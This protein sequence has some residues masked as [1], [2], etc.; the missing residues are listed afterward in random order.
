MYDFIT[1]AVL[2]A[3]IDAIKLIPFLYLTYLFMEFLEHRTGERVVNAI[4]KAGRF[5]PLAGGLLGAVPQC[6]FS[7]VASG[8]YSGRIITVGTLIAVFLST[9]DEMVAVMLSSAAKDPENLARL[10]KILGIKVVGG[11]A[12]GFAADFIL[13]NRKIKPDKREIGEICDH[14]GCHCEEHGIFVSAA[15]HALKILAFIFAVTLAINTVIFFVG[16]DSLRTVLKNVPILGEL[17]AG[18]FGLIPNCASSVVLTEL[19][20]DGVLTAGQLLSGLF[21]GTGVGLLVLFRSNR[22]IKENLVILLSVFAAGVVL[23]L[24]VG[25]TGL[26]TVLGL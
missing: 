17:L 24:L 20:L 2:D 22:N 11:I 9:S 5:G 4:G 6:G 19:Y 14:E 26:S 15:L 10:A 7:A 25:V 16:E 21:T 13:R 18:V 12:V 3:V 23:G 8:L 1:E